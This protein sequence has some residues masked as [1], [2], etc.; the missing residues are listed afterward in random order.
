MPMFSLPRAE[1]VIALGVAGLNLLIA[2][3]LVTLSLALCVVVS[4]LA[5]LPSLSGRPSRAM[6]RIGRRR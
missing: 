6:V 3:L 2:S 5:A 4:L 1:P